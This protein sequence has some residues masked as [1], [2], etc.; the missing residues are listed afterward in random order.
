MHIRLFYEYVR[1]AENYLLPRS[2]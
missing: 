1:F 2:G